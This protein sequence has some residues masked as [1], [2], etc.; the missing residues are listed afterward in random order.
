[1]PGWAGNQS[2]GFILSRKHIYKTAPDIRHETHRHQH[3][4]DPHTFLMP[5]RHRPSQD[6]A[7][8]TAQPA[9]GS[10]WV[11]SKSW[12]LIQ[13]DFPFSFSSKHC[14]PHPPRESVCRRHVRVTWA[15]HTLQL[16][17]YCGLPLGHPPLRAETSVSSSCGNRTHTLPHLNQGLTSLVRGSVAASALRQDLGPAPT[18]QPSAPF[19]L[20]KL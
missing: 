4:P 8:G 1:M 10:C 7:W 19:L 18:F 20:S 12:G 3:T 11:L 16:P 15:P 14:W 17:C 9:P 5:T 2:W 6:P 13:H